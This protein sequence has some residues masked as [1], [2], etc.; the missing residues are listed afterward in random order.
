MHTTYVEHDR[1]E[2]SQDI[3]QLGVARGDAELVKDLSLDS[4]T[5]TASVRVDYSTGQPRGWV[6][7]TIRP[8]ARVV[9]FS[10][11]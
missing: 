5:V 3:P 8:R 10:P 6:E 11:A 7:M 4:E 9:S 1:I 2:I